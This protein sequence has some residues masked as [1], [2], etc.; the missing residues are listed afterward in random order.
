MAAFIESQRAI[1]FSA[2]YWPGSNLSPR[3][4]IKYAEL[5]SPVEVYEK[6]RP[7]HVECDPSWTSARFDFANLLIARRVDNCQRTRIFITEPG[8]KVFCVRVVPHL[9]RVR[10]KRQAIDE[11]ESVP[12]K[13]L[14]SAVCAIRHIKPVE[15]I[16]IKCALWFAL[17]RDAGDP[18]PSL[19]VDNFHRIL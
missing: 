17:P 5:G 10:A 1:V 12:A 16:R 11:F 4:A 3:F 2:C 19:E 13:N 6:S 9:V 14:A 18:I 7:R 8:V 15:V